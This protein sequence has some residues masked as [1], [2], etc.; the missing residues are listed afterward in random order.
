MFIETFLKLFI[1]FLILISNRERFKL[2]QSDFFESDIHIIYETS[3]ISIIIETDSFDYEMFEKIWA[4]IL[5]GIELKVQSVYFYVHKESF[6]SSTNDFSSSNNSSEKVDQLKKLSKIS[7]PKIVISDFPENGYLPLMVSSY[8]EDMNPVQI[9]CYIDA[10]RIEQRKKNYRKHIGEIINKRPNINR[11]NPLSDWIQTSYQMH[12]SD[13]SIGS[14]FGFKTKVTLN[15]FANNTMNKKGD[16]NTIE[17]VV[18]CDVVMVKESVVRELL[19]YTKSSMDSP[20]S[21]LALSLVNNKK[22]HNSFENLLSNKFIQNVDFFPSSKPENQILTINQN[23]A[24]KCPSI[25]KS[26]KKNVTFSVY[27]PCYKR[28]YFRLFFS[29]MNRQTLQP[30]YYILVQNRFHVYLDHEFMFNKY[31]SSTS[32]RPIYKVWMLNFNTFF[33]FPNLVTSL[34]NTDFVIRFDDDHIPTDSHMLSR[35]VRDE[36]MENKIGD[37]IE[38][39]RI[40]ILNIY[41]GDF[42]SRKRFDINCRRK[43]PDY[44]ASPY[45]YRPIQMKLSGRLRPMFLAGGEDA[46]FGLS[47]SILCR[48]E[49]KYVGF[50][51]TDLSFDKNRHELDDEINQYKEKY[52]HVVGELIH[53][54]YAYYVKIGLKPNCWIGFVLDPRDRINGSVYLHTKFF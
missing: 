24:F 19:Y 11:K 10:R 4:P 32:A 41:V 3:N 50:R 27:I 2:L 17:K 45:I 36:F 6:F 42:K 13:R 8:T 15:E 44:V 14:V 47:A 28:D 20:S 12:L 52:V 31:L 51:V 49:S 35:V 46:H 23:E 33:V 43:L 30:S 7:F 1:L 39:D 25:F 5:L 18:G 22:I 34:L 53:N 29:Q 40:S 21:F 9:I 38:G 26:N 48:T 16:E 37:M 54:V